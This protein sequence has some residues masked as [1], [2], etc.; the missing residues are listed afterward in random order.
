[1]VK[2]EVVKVRVRV[3]SEGKGEGEGEDM[4]KR[5]REKKGK[6]MGEREGERI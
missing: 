1:M 3:K 2:G 6:E 4:L 5:V